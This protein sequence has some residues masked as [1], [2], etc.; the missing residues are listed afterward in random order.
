MEWKR[1]GYVIHCRMEL[2]PAKT[3]EFVDVISLCLVVS[4]AILSAAALLVFQP[5]HGAVDFAVLGAPARVSV[6]LHVAAPAVP[7]IVVVLAVVVVL[8]P[9]V[10]AVPEIDAHAAAV[11][12][13]AV[14]ALAAHA[15]EYLA[16]AVPGE[17]VA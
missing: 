1:L 9:V 5:T 15:V 3:W 14:L 6:V 7:A 17:G 10:V 4:A 8:V 13:F 12:A 11:L 16:A 2:V